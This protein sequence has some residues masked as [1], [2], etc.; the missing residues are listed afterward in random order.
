MG[1][2]EFAHA[3]ESQ[4]AVVW[5]ALVVWEHQ[6]D[7]TTPSQPSLYA[8]NNHVYLDASHRY[9]VLNP[10]AIAPCQER[11]LTL[12]V[13]DC[14]PVQPS[15][16][17]QVCDRLAKTMDQGEA[18][19]ETEAS[20]VA[21]VVS[22]NEIP[23]EPLPGT[24]DPGDA[25]QPSEEC[26]NLPDLVQA[27]LA[28][29][30]ELYPA[31]PQIHDAWEDQGQL[32][33]VLE[34]RQAFPSLVQVW[35]DTDIFPI[36]M[37]NWLYDIAKLWDILSPWRCCQSLLDL[38]NLRIDEDHILCLQRLQL[39][40]L[41]KPASLQAL[42]ALWR[43]L[44]ETSQRTMVASFLQVSSALEI[45]EI[46]DVHQLQLELMAI[47]EQ[48]QPNDDPPEFTN[49]P[50]EVQAML[51]PDSASSSAT[52]TDDT[53]QTQPLENEV[54]NRAMNPLIGLGGL[55]FM[56]QEADDDGGE[57]EDLP[58]VVLPMKLVSLDDAGRT[59]IGRQRKHN[60]DFFT[61]KTVLQKNDGPNGRTL[62]AKGLYILCDG[63]G[64][65]EGGEVAS[66]LAVETLVN[67]F[68]QHWQEQLPGEQIIRD[69]I[70]LANDTIFQINQQGLRSGSGRMGTTLVMLLIHDTEA[71]IAHVGDSRLYRF[72]RRQG[73]EI[74]TVD[75]EV[76]QR[77]IH[78]GVDPAIAYARP[79]AYQLTQALGPRD[80]N[81]VE[82]DIAFLELNEDSLFLLCSDGLTD[83]NLLE[84][85]WETH[86][87]PLIS[88]GAN[89]DQGVLELIDLANEV[90]GHD[91]ITTIAVRAK[92]RPNVPPVNRR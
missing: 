74:M 41:E 19:S 52:P 14:L 56:L 44:F 10:E 66:A 76:G 64:G 31:M 17:D 89:L 70:Y 6:P 35:N 87:E 92:V 23:T 22:E 25:A 8:Q 38:E 30:D 77:E 90:N 48:L 47:A 28:V 43:S 49:L 65:H 39:D 88:S 61:I 69:G 29:Q 18:D 27:Y 79:D 36:Q 68:E 51:D 50:D 34:E 53:E 72:S 13:V 83:D 78:R 58:T 82:P 54:T 4:P 63:M 46:A 42:G 21:P 59:D 71:A 5:H 86:V 11:E 75:H 37:L 26:L 15:F 45:G 1:V 60:E 84:T 91:N 33:L 7:T 3:P 16:L 20:T 85:H 9:Q 12:Q 73:L 55:G 67:Y 62:K 40:D 80:E 57:G 24:L 2:S 81:F 32:C